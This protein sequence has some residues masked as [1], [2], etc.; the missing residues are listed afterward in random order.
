[1]LRP[2]QAKARIKSKLRKNKEQSKEKS[3]FL[4]RLDR[5]LEPHLN[6]VFF[7]SLFFTISFGGLAV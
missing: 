6:Q 2:N 5:W 7:F 3:A 4:D 1:M